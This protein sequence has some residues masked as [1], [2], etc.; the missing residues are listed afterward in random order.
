MKGQKYRVCGLNLFDK[1]DFN[2]LKDAQR[3][4]NMKVRNAYGCNV[5]LNLFKFNKQTCEYERVNWKYDY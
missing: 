3:Y 2:T 1:A 5:R 4:A